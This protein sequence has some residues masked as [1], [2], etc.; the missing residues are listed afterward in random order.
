MIHSNL[1]LNSSYSTSKIFKKDN[2]Q[3]TSVF[4]LYYSFVLFLEWC[5]QYCSG[6]AL[7]F[8]EF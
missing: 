2:F 6:F 4:Y 5:M 8:S 3:L 7:I 1:L